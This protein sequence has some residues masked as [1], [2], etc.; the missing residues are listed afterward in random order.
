MLS[1]KELNNVEDNCWRYILIEI[2]WSMLLQMTNFL[3]LIF[4]LN[5]V[6]YKPLLK[7]LD[8]RD[9]RISETQQKAKNFSEETEKMI[10][11]YNEKLQL[12]KIEAMTQKNNAKKDAA[13]K[14]NV[15][16]EE[17]RKEAEHH[18]LEVKHQITQ[19]IE[20]ARRELEP[21]LEKMAITIAEQVLGRKVA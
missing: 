18:L 10:S 3:L 19:E 1:C 4:I 14:A 5:I 16:I 8:E 15:I 11:I 7:I 21:E 20:T 6:L 17:S 12:A 13:E 9:K 2:N